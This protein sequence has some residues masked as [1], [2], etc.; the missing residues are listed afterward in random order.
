[1]SGEKDKLYDAPLAGEW[2]KSSYSAGN[3]NA[4]VQLMSI[5]GGFAVGDSKRPDLPPLRYTPAELQAFLHAAKA[6]E[7]DHLLDG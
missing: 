5:A 3:G 6:G 7:F 1:M 4:C 2:V